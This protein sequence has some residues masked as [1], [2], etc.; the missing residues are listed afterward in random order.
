MTDRKI[1]EIRERIDE[2]DDRLL[3]LLN[4][5][6]MLVVAL[7]KVK[8]EHGLQLFDPERERQIHER[9]AD[10][11]GG[12]LPSEAVARVFERIID[13]ARRLERTEVYDKAQE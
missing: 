11:N 13:E 8:H 10:A 3:Q 2:I 12:P 7:A 9:L 5:R 1:D 4:D 6:A